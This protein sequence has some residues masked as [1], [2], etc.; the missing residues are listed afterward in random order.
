MTQPYYKHGETGFELSQTLSRN[1]QEMDYK[2]H[3][4]EVSIQLNSQ[5]SGWTAEVFI[6]YFE[7]G[8]NVVQTLR[9]D[10]TFT[11]PDLA[12]QSG[13]EYAKKWIDDRTSGS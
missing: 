8:K 2:N 11:S 5:G 4:L 13:V 3:Q 6:T 7:N 9:M 10:Q 1:A 12:V